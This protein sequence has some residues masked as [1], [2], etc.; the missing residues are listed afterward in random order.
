MRTFAT[1]LSGC[2]PLVTMSMQPLQVVSRLT[3]S[4]SLGNDVIDFHLVS[5]HEVPSTCPALPLLLL[6][7]SGDSRG[8]VWLAS[9]SSAPIDPVSVVWTARALDFHMSL[10]GGVRVA[11]EGYPAVGCL[12]RPPFPIVHSPVFARDPVL[13]LVWVAGACPSSQHRVDRVVKGL[14]DPCAGNVRVVMAPAHTLRVQRLHQRLLSGVL[15]AVTRLTHFFTMSADR[16]LAG[17]DACF[18]TLQ[19]SSAICPR[20]GLPH[21]V[22][23]DVQA[24]E[25]AS[26]GVLCTYEGMGDPRLAGFPSASYVLPPLWSDRLTLHHALALCV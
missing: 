22:L 26:R 16:R 17:F 5:G 25:V 24:A 20:V 11:S 6:Q 9:C 10:D 7:E 4:L 2:F 21:W 18:E 23:S 13:L 19:A 15:R 12:E 8:Y 1:S 14:T 3:P